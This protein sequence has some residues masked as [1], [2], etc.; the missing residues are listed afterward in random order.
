MPKSKNS[1]AKVP[2]NGAVQK[3]GFDFEDWVAKKCFGIEATHD[4]SKWDIDINNEDYRP[5]K[6]VPNEFRGISISIKTAKVFS[7]IGL[8]DIIRQ[9]RINETFGLICGFWMQPN[10]REK[11][12]AQIVTL[13][14]TGAQWQSLW[15]GLH[16]KDIKRL[17]DTIKDRNLHYEKAREAAKEWKKQFQCRTYNF[18]V[19]PKIDS[20]NQRRVQT[21]IPYKKAIEYSQ[22]TSLIQ[23][24]L[25]DKGI[26]WGKKFPNP[27]NSPPRK[28]KN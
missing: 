9:R 28:F 14:F 7:P 12:I 24:H 27:M 11:I 21:S 20:K 17:D 2:Q 1:Q 5:R 13:I 19:N 15:G 10:Q 25:H 8:G 23:G 16:P 3:H 6:N 26:L 22:D 18:I 4:S